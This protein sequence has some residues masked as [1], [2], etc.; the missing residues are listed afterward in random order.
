MNKDKPESAPTAAGTRSFVVPVVG[1][2]KPISGYG[3]IGNTR[4]VA[5]VGYDGSIDWCCM[6]KLSSPSIFAALLDH[7]KGGSW[8]IQPAGRASS[9]QSYLEETN[10]LRTEFRDD[11]ARVVLTDFMP[12][13]GTTGAWSTPP[14]IHRMVQCLA[15]S[16]EM[17]FKFKPVLNYGLTVPRLSRVENG[18]S[19]KNRKQE[20][21]LSSD[22]RLEVAGSGVD[23]RFEISHGEKKVF[24]LSY[25][26]SVPRR[27]AEY[28]SERQRARTEVFWMDWAAQIRYRGRW[29]S[30]VVRS[31]LALK[32]LVYAPTGAIVAAPTTSLPE[33]IGGN[34]NWDYRYSWIRDSAS[35]L[36]AFHKI[37]CKSETE[38]YLHWLIDN[39]PS[40]DL[41][42]RLMYDIEGDPHVKEKSLDHLDGYM[43]SKPVRIGNEASEQVQYDA[44][45]YMLD[46]LYFSSSH[47]S[48]IDDEMYFRFVKPLANFLTEHWEE[49]GNGI[50]EIRNKHEHYVYTKAWCYAGLDR[51]VKIAE[52]AGHPDDIPRWKATMKQIKEEVLRRG[53]NGKKQSFVIHYGSSN[54]DA[55]SLMLPLIGFLPVDSAKMKSTV[56]AIAKE[57]SDG[58]LVYRY[59]ADDGLK[60]TE[61]AFLLCGFWLVACLARL[62]QVER[63][64]ENFQGLL[65]H[66]NHLG[67]F[68]EEVDPKTG[69]ALGN[70][71]QAFSHV[72][73]ILAASE[74]DE[75]LDQRTRTVE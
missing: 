75:A 27:I 44:Y 36:W 24:V 58:P 67:L 26:E 46:S 59:K 64:S 43:G 25:G 7:R 63:A 45:G 23:M 55:A 32:L 39:N 49:P 50:W 37:G 54:L 5:L 69:M 56:E 72:G 70:F 57:L 60:G 68:S 40:L 20:M 6:P 4:T 42:L 38:A 14:E 2:Y 34:R 12:C 18:L 73:L 51:A 71:P 33:A 29:R 22:F 8:A 15:G 52:A 53:W 48:A 10:I 74:L 16:M 9:T 41:D 3:V 61:G 21:V 66:A 1:D 30:A 47:G 13:S 11:A 19:I 31:A 35:S 65:G 17:R 28:R 62:G